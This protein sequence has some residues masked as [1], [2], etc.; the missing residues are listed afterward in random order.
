LQ[1]KAQGFSNESYGL[2]LSLNGLIVVLLELP[3]SAFTQ[4]HPTTRMVA[5]GAF[6]VGFGFLLVGWSGTLL[7]LAGC[8]VIFTLGEILGAPPSA[9]FVADRSPQHLRGRYQA[10]FGTMFGLAAVVGPIAGTVAFHRRPTLLWGACGVLGLIA[11]ALA[12]AAGR[13]PVPDIDLE[14][15]PH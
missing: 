11:A 9:V 13:R 6:L 7:A 15:P 4:R 12:L 2:L 14:G 10:A 5:L 8:T 3:L 1:V